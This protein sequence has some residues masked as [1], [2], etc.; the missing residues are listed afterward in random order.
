MEF[1]KHF[2]Q[3]LEERSIHDKWVERT[4]QDPDQVNSPGDGT[5]HYIKQIPENGDRWLRIIVNVDVVPN[6]AVTAFFDRRL[7]RVRDEDQS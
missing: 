7:R 5:N 4:I 2:R 3:M 6:K 1:T